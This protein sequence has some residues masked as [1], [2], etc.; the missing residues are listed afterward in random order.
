MGFEGTP[1]RT[2]ILQPSARQPDPPSPRQSDHGGGC[3]PIVAILGR[4]VAVTYDLWLSIPPP[5]CDHESHAAITRTPGAGTGRSRPQPDA[6]ALTGAD[7]TAAGPAA[8]TLA[9]DGV[10]GCASDFTHDS[11]AVQP[12]H[13]PIA[14]R[15]GCEAAKRISALPHLSHLKA[16]SEK[17]QDFR[18]IEGAIAI[19]AMPEIHFLPNVFDAR[20]SRRRMQR[21]DESLGISVDAALQDDG[22]TRN[23]PKH[24]GCSAAKNGNARRPPERLNLPA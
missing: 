15:R 3:A 16:L 9:T 5:I 17:G 2:G 11:E 8:S 20:S 13:C 10:A 21:A 14:L 4:A 7:A 12:L 18:L 19:D 22:R 6:V 24:S 1:G 23:S